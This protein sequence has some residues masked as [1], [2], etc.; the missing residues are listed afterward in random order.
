MTTVGNVAGPLLAYEVLT[1]FFLE[2]TMLG[3]MLFGR[4]RVSERVQTLATFRFSFSNIVMLLPIPAMTLVLFVVMAQSL[5]RLPVRL[6]TNNQYGAAVPF[7]CT[8]GIFLLAFYGL[9]Y[10]LCSR[11]WWWT[12]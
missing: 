1:A 5:K 7:A 2:A 6:A 12:A 8:V 4:G 10:S 9:A 3:I 11:G